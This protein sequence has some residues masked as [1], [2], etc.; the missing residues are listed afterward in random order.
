MIHM[1]QRA[2]APFGKTVSV[3]PGFGV[4]CM[5]CCW[6]I[7]PNGLLRAT[8]TPACLLVAPI[9]CFPSYISL[10]ISSRKKRKQQSPKL[11]KNN[12]N[13]EMKTRIQNKK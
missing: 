9:L 13:L 10:K 12:T 6:S 1:L 4:H 3:Y 8:S 2:P 7:A 5:E 11:E